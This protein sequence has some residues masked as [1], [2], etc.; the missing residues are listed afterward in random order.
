MM[1]EILVAQAVQS[2]WLRR[3]HIA[4]GDAKR[5]KRAKHHCE[6]METQRTAWIVEGG[7]YNDDDDFKAPFDDEQQASLEDHPISACQ[8]IA[9]VDHLKDASRSP[10]IFDD[11]SD[12][13]A[14]VMLSNIF[15]R[16]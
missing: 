15:H 7:T 11:I 4:L 14:T 5:P 9:F 1:G 13:L 16:E 8:A 10:A 6:G 2:T 3:L 12:Q